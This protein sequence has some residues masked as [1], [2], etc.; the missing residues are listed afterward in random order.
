MSYDAPD[1]NA[2]E[3]ILMRND[4]INNDLA[5]KY[6]SE[7]LDDD[8]QFVPYDELPLR[9]KTNVQKI[10]GRLMMKNP[11]E[12]RMILFAPPLSGKKLIIDQMI[13]N[14]EFFFSKS[15]RKFPLVI[16]IKPNLEDTLHEGEFI[17]LAKHFISK[18]GKEMKESIFVTDSHY[19]ASL[20]ENENCG[21]ILEIN[22]RDFHEEIIQKDIGY[23]IFGSWEKIDISGE[24]SKKEAIELIEK[25]ALPEMNDAYGD[26][27]NKEDAE[28]FVDLS[29]N[30]ILENNDLKYPGLWIE[31]FK[32]WAISLFLNIDDAPRDI[33]SQNAFADRKDSIIE[34][35]NSGDNDETLTPEDLFAQILGKGIEGNNLPPGI[36]VKTLTGE[37]MEAMFGNKSQEKDVKSEKEE[38]KFNSLASI[39]R[40]LKKSIIGQDNSI[41]DLVESLAIPM[42]NLNDK[43]KPLLSALFLGPTGVGKTQTVYS[44]A[45]NLLKDKEMNVI[46][47][48]MSE[49]SEEHTV[50]KLIGAP[51]GYVGFENGGLLAN[52]VKNNPQS[53]ILLD[54]VEKAHPSIWNAF[55]QIFD[56]GRLTSNTNEVIDFSQ[57]IILMTSNLGSRDLIR[58]NAGFSTS[59]SG[60]Y[61]LNDKD[62]ENEVNKAIQSFFSPELIN[63]LDKKI[64]F[65]PLDENTMSKIVKKE[66]NHALE[67]IRK[68]GID[69]EDAGNDIVRKIT[70]E[71]QDNKYGARELQR[72]VKKEITI[73]LAKAILTKKKKES[74]KINIEE[75]SIIIEKLDKAKVKK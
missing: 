75:N 17:E 29:Y 68:N 28:Y 63:R 6:F 9:I 74:L 47:L 33:K 72:I 58:K 64:I 30:L 51:P 41:H 26:S 15:K 25:Y 10:G 11:K 65:S 52:S 40:N 24:I 48:D 70:E 56:A 27:F 57:T 62:L 37:E 20:L 8:S 53:I 19:M 3:S 50:H 35:F 67:D 66:I 54:E 46:R 31:A 12:R 55:L 71:I 7:Y 1:S 45:K 42:A 60:E 32:R 18:Y 43:E 39:E 21:I 4:F 59:L 36:E 69:V 23:S 14:E 22:R 61:V 16:K 2:V 5:E 49:Y 44:L 34:I 73:P 38:F 13:M